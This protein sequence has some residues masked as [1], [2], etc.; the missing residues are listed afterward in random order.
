MKTPKVNMT[1]QRR[2]MHQTSGFKEA[3]MPCTIKRNSLKKRM[4]RMMRK[5]RT[6]RKICKSFS[7]ETFPPDV[8]YPTIFSL[9]DV[10]TTKTSN[11]FHTR[12]A[13]SRCAKPLPSAPI[14]SINSMVKATAKTYSRPWRYHG[15][16]WPRLWMDQSA[17]QPMEEAF[18]KI[19]TAAAYSKRRLHTTFRR[20]SLIC[21]IS[22]QSC[23]PKRLNRLLPP[24]NEP[25]H[26]ARA[27]ERPDQP[28]DA[29]RFFRL[30]P[31]FGS[32]Q[33]LCRSSLLDS[34]CPTSLPVS[35]P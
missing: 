6:R 11:K 5:M 29:A 19:M 3:A 1:R 28:R 21:L 13:F 4:T 2:T 33:A 7:T 17:S 32:W 10:R 34:V 24:L 8:T 18:A 16:S 14:R 31:F 22:D 27:V 23:S 15:I 9:H 30:L 26:V 25:L 20:P 12:F 35:S